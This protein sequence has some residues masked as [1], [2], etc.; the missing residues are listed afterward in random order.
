MARLC[1]MLLALLC[2]FFG[3][4]DPSVAVNSVPTTIF[5]WNVQTLFDG[6]Y[7][8]TEFADYQPGT[9]DWNQTRYRHRL[10]TLNEALNQAC[11]T[12]ADLILLYEVENATV[13]SDWAQLNPQLQSYHLFHGKDQ[14]QSFG[15]ALFSKQKPLHIQLHSTSWNGQTLRPLV[16]IH[17]GEP[18]RSLL[19]LFACHWKSKYGGARYT[20]DARRHQGAIIRR[21]MARLAALAP[22]AQV[23]V[24]GDLNETLDEYEQ[25]GQSYP[26]ALMDQRHWRGDDSESLW[27][28]QDEPPLD[29]IPQGQILLAGPDQGSYWYRGQWEQI[30]HI[31]WSPGLSDRRGLEISSAKVLNSQPFVTVDGRPMAFDRDRDYGLSDHLPLRISLE[32]MP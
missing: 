21:R 13:V 19:V 8:G 25:A 9:S 31:L 7:D 22:D 28:A 32:W 5:S 2:A 20:E 27:V 12:M 4:A 16:E 18:G 30:D 3:C 29:H 23:L 11:P 10:E 14:G 24:V 15:C 26:C 17:F 6:S 1:V